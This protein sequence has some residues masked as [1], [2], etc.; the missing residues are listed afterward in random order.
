[1]SIFLDSKK[2]FI[3][4]SVGP[5]SVADNNPEDVKKVKSAHEK[6][7]N[8]L[9][10]RQIKDREEWKKE[11]EE[12]KKMILHKQSSLFNK[13]KIRLACYYTGRK[14]LSLLGRRYG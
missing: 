12:M 11:M 5:R 6:E 9:K 14:Q 7:I 3:K 4:G 13:V 1:M 10:A 8:S 2:A